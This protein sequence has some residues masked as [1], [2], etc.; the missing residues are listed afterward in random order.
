MRNRI[1]GI[2]GILW[3]GGVLVSFMMR[4]EGIWGGSYGLGQLFG[5]L[6]GLAMFVAGIYYVAKGDRST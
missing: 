5:L 1:M 2:I 6:F 4:E 3:G